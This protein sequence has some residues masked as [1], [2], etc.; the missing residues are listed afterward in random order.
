MTAE[1]PDPRASRTPGWREVII[2]AAAIVATVLGA[3][4]V[5][6]ILPE[7][8]QALVFHSPIAIVVLLAGTAFVLWRVSSGQPR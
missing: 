5:T 2:L 8:L 3:A 1:G 4:V 7:Q 6:S